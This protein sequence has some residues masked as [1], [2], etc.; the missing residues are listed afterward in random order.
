MEKNQYESV[1]ILTPVLSE[2][3]MDDAIA[4]F[5]Q[6]ITE[7]NGEIVHEENWGLTKLAYPIQKKVTG[8]YHIYEFSAPADIVGKLELAYRRDEQVMRYVTIRLDKH[9]VK[10]NERRRKGEFNKPKSTEKT[11]KELAS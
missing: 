9:A 10:Y 5:R 8:F 1:I 3:Q 4:S 11:D 6:L 2:K 7:N